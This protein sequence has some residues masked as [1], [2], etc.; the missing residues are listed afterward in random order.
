MSSFRAA[1]RRVADTTQRSVGTKSHANAAEFLG[2]RIRPEPIY[3]KAALR[4]GCNDCGAEAMLLFP[5][6]GKTSAHF[7]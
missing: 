3:R 6:R 4:L 7:A 5:Q 2:A 1:E